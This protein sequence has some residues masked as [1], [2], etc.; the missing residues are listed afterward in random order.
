MFGDPRQH[1]HMMSGVKR[2]A[3]SRKTPEHLR[4]HLQKRLE[5]GTMA[6][7]GRKVIG[8]TGRTAIEP[9]DGTPSYEATAEAAR[10]R[11]DVF[12]STGKSPIKTIAQTPRYNSAPLKTVVG[13]TA[14]PPVKTTVGNTASPPRKTIVG[15]TAAGPLKTT[16]GNLG[17]GGIGPLGM[18][19]A[20]RGPINAANPSTLSRSLGN[21]D[22][23]PGRS[24]S[25]VPA[26]AQG[27]PNPSM[28]WAQPWNTTGIQDGGMG[29]AAKSMSIAP[30]PKGST[31][32]GVRGFNRGIGREI[33]GA[34]GTPRRAGPRRPSQ[35]FGE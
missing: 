25:S 21:G 27:P 23:N 5:G 7:A 22:G 17:K 4:P 32:G 13:S 6:F 14:R 33:P 15:S 28:D 34:R 8:S 29:P 35:F 19:A 20:D 30:T 12:A 3:A 26:P 16:P 2:A 31:G 10:P 24:V 9:R 1:E 11:K 18:A